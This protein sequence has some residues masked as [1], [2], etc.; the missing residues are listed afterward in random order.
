MCSRRRKFTRPDR[1][2]G[3]SGSDETIIVINGPFVIVAASPEV[4]ILGIR[5]KKFPIYR[6]GPKTRR[7]QQQRH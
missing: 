2:R 3:R 1:G 4:K 6:A 5:E 7:S